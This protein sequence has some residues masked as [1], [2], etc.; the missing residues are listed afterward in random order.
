MLHVMNR[1]VQTLQWS[2]GCSRQW[3]MLKTSLYLGLQDPGDVSAIC[4]R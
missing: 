2:S 3:C 1:I 4:P